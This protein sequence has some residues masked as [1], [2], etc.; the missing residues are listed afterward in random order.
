MAPDDE[1]RDPTVKDRLAD[2]SLDE[3]IDEATQRELARWFGLPSFEQLADKGQRPMSA[4]D[5][6]E[7]IANRE[8][9]QKAMAA[10]DPALL[11]AIR[12]RT[13]L[14]H[15]LIT[16]EATLDVRVDPSVA[17]VDLGMIERLGALADPHERELPDDLQDDMRER[18]PQALLRDLHRPETDFQLAFE[19]TEVVD[20]RLDIVAEVATAMTTRWQLPPVGRSP[21]S[22]ARALW[23]DVRR[24]RAQP[25]PALF[26]SLT[27]VNR[28]IVP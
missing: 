10:V 20:Q 19:I 2:H 5:D 8:R 25:W 1:P 16:F 28:R 7:I 17:K 9:K 18:A 6:P 22:E 13:Q 11:E 12:Q 27:L 4:D 21:A 23:A 26:A 14:G 24:I 3:V 15:T